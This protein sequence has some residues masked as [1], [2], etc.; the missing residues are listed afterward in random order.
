MATVP[1]TGRRALVTGAA[2]GLG[3]A[4]AEALGAAGC[5]VALCDL[6]PEI[7]AIAQALEARGITVYAEQADVSDAAEVRSF[8]DNAAKALGGL[9]L[10]VNNAG[11][12]TVTR[13][14]KDPWD[15]TVADFD[16]VV[17]VNFKGTY[18]VGRAAVPHLIQ[19]GGD[20]VNITTDH[21]HTCGYPDALDH[22]EAP[23]CPWAGMPRPPLG[24]PGFDVYDASKW[25]IKGLT[26]VWARELAKHGVRVN[27]FGMGATAT[28]MYL[29]HL[30]DNPVPPGVMTPEAVAAVLI[31]LLAEGPEGRTGDC[32]QLWVGH[33]C[34]LGPPGVEAEMTARQLGRPPHP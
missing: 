24:G 19:A 2:Q 31:D 6:R 26:T 16:D 20:L 1:L 3:H 4:Y 17:G 15:K 25:A 34:E 18:L 11:V 21:I 7:S 14:T 29:N 5:A 9:D 27:S 28:P 8:V 10:V 12:V 22:A 13:P 32:I 30:G 23:D 33:P